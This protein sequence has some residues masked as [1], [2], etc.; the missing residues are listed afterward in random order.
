MGKSAQGAVWLDADMLSPYDFYQFWINTEDA[1]VTRFLKIY[2]FLPL[3]EI[4]E[5]GRLQ[6]AD[7]R[8][9]KEVLAYEVTRLTHGAEEADRARE[10]ARS[11]FGAGEVSEAMPTTELDAGRL[12][13]GI[14]VVELFA[15][16][17]LV[18]SRSEAR[19]LIQQGGAYVNG[20]AVNSPEATVTAD[21]LQDGAIVLRA[22][23]KRYHRVVAV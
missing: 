19:R 17:G 13:A 2:T 3:D 20:E 18:R 23:K 11:L 6:G 12:E 16:V 15:E 10:A 5:L 21:A 14:P 1:N 4:E 7:I 22:G 8:Q 9:A